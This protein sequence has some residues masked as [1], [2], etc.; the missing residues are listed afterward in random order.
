M[1]LEFPPYHA[2]SD[3]DIDPDTISYSRIVYDFV[4]NFILI[5]LI[6]QMMSGIIIDKFGELRE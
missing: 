2:T 5:I 3:D 1:G 6:V 4:F